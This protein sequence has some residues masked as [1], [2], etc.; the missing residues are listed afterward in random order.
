LLNVYEKN[1]GNDDDEKIES[2][3][4]KLTGLTL[5]EG[6]PPAEWTRNWNLRA[7]ED[8]TMAKIA[9]EPRE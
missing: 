7:D 5:P 8:Q 3:L 2:A 9:I 1:F 6:S 4:S